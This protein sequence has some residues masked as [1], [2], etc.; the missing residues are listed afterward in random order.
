MSNFN[1][2]HFCCAKVSSRRSD[3]IQIFCDHPDRGIC[4]DVVICAI[5]FHK[6]FGKGFYPTSGFNNHCKLC[7]ESVLTI[8]RNVMLVELTLYQQ[9]LYHLECMEHQISPEFLKLNFI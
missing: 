9:D 5:C 8:A 3:G 4:V 6:I 2:C 7:G 1:E